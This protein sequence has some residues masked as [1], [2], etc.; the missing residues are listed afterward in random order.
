MILHV[1]PKAKPELEAVADQLLGQ[2]VFVGW[3]HL[4][5]ALVVAVSDDNWKIHVN[6]QSN[7]K[8][9]WVK[10]AVE[11]PLTQ[12]KNLQQKAIVER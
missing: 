3:P 12:Q 1:V 2:S 10:E 6:S 8:S 7:K 4:L 9:D 5:E 11:G